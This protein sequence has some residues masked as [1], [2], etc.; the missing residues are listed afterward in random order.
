MFVREVM[1]KNQVG[2]HAR[3]ATFFIQKANEFKS[4]IWIEKEERRVNAKSLL[5]ILSL[6][7]VG[8]TNIKVIADS[9]DEKAAVDALVELVESGF[10]EE[11]R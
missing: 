2:L 3:P 9:A 8:G 10:S 5:G 4:S 7:I 1:V 6:G 11:N